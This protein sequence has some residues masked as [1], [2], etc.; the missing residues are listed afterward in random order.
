LSSRKD[1]I[2]IGGPPRA[3]EQLL[4]EAI[5]SEV[6]RLTFGDRR[7]LANALNEGWPFD[8]LPPAA[9]AMFANLAAWAW[10]DSA[11]TAPR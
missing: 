2:S 10:Q 9:K 5:V 7:Q 8:T 11:P 3:P 6:G 4:Y 1:V